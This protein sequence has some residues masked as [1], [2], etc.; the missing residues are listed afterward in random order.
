MKNSPLKE[1]EAQYLKILKYS[2]AQGGSTGSSTE[3]KLGQELLKRPGTFFSFLSMYMVRGDV[4]ICE[5]GCL[6]SPE[7]GV[8]APGAGDA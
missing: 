7:E 2:S 1:V 4:C 6:Q 3:S 5:C 8:G